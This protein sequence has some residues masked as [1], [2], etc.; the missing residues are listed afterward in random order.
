MQ[1]ESDVDETNNNN[2]AVALKKHCHEYLLLHLRRNSLI[3]QIF[4]RW[5]EL[6]QMLHRNRAMMLL[7]K[8]VFLENKFLSQNCQNG[9]KLSL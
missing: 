9:L 1:R 8:F 7:F 6:K 3:R 4:E 5:V 2:N